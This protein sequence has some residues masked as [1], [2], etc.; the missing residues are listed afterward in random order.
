MN[1]FFT[2]LVITAGFILAP[3]IVAFPE[4]ITIT[5]YFPS[6][7]GVYANLRS[8]QLAVGSGY[9]ASPISDGTLIV[10]S[11]IGI[12]TP[13]P[14]YEVDVNGNIATNNILLRSRGVW[15]GSM[16]W[17]KA[18]YYSS[19]SGVTYCSSGSYSGYVATVWGAS[20]PTDGSFLCCS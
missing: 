3:L 6:P 20:T 15:V 12:A 5:T 10:Q 7:Y 11:R 16:S 4:D 2:K 13:N 1:K 9:R 18:N 17:C 19:N 14:G 8:N